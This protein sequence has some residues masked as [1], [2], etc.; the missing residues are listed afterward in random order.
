VAVLKRE[1]VTCL[2]TRARRVPRARNRLMAR[3]AAPSSAPKP[4]RQDRRLGGV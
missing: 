3:A 4:Q 2:R 1:L